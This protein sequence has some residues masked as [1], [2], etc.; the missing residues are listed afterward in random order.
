MNNHRQEPDGIDGGHVHECLP[1]VTGL[2]DNLVV[3]G[4]QLHIQTELLKSPV[5]CITTQVFSSGRVLFSRKSE[6]PPEFSNSGS[7]GKIRDLM[8]DQHLQVIRE[9]NKKTAQVSGTSGSR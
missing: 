9:I 2:N 3:L 7:I 1:S 6:C 8:K 5:L 4:K